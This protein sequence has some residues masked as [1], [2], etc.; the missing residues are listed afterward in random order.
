MK[1]KFLIFAACF[2]LMLTFGAINIKS[3][4]SYCYAETEQTTVVEE[5]TTTEN[6]TFF[7]RTYQWFEDNYKVILQLIGDIVIGYIVLRLSNKTKKSLVNINTQ[8]TNT[9]NT[10]SDV[11]KVV[12]ELIV[13]YNVLDEKLKSY[14]DTQDENYKM[15]ASMVVQTKAILEILATVYANSKNLP[16][17]VKDLVNLKYADVLKTIN[18]DKKLKEIADSVK[19]VVDEVKEKAENAFEEQK[20]DTMEE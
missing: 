14:T 17:G 1:K 11:V 6:N 18:E 16:Q 3:K 7:G 10:Q 20:T 4:T 13:G 9:N 12:N 19:G 2:S 15:V 5:E 8:T